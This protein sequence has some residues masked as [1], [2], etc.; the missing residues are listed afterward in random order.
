M[1]A[2]VE[3]SRRRI[4]ALETELDI[5]GREQAVGIDVGERDDERAT[6]KLGDEQR[7]AGRARGALERRRRRW[8]T[9]SSRCARSCAATQPVEGTASEPTRP[10]SRRS[11]ADAAERA[12]RC[13]TSCS[14]LQAKLAD[15]AGRDAADPA[16]AST[17]RPSPPSSATGPASRSAAWCK[18]EIETV[19]KLADTLGAARHRPGP[20]A[21]R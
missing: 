12:R 7:A 17:R 10:A 3:D 8:S 11:A 15:A 1:P 2:E 20:R 4:E 21:A 19:L 16:D 14:E 5:I 6:S 9:R 18:N 13:S